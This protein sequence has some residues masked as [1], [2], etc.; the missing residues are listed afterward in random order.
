MELHHLKQFSVVLRTLHFL[1]GLMHRKQW[2]YPIGIRALEESN[3]FCSLENWQVLSADN[4]LVTCCPKI[5][6]LFIYRFFFKDIHFLG[7]NKVKTIFLLISWSN[8][9]FDEI[10]WGQLAHKILNKRQ[11]TIKSLK[12]KFWWSKS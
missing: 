1:W 11:Y 12:I 3:S 7:K 9:H 6:F 10:L 8:E 4:S 2:T 5:R